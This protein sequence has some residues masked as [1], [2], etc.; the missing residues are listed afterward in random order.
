LVFHLGDIGLQPGAPAKSHG[1]RGI[2]RKKSA[3]T[4][5]NASNRGTKGKKNRRKR[6]V[7]EQKR[8]KMDLN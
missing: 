4:C 6:L 2:V 8:Q 3:Q 1:F 7:K 5:R